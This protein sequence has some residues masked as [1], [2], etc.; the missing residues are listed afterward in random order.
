MSAFQL[1]TSLVHWIGVCE[2]VSRLMARD[3]PLDTSSR[4]RQ[5]AQGLVRP[6]RGRSDRIA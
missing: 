1:G 6:I 2:G 4:E 5:L 3:G